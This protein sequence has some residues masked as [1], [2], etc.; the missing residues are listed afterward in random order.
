[1]A[2]RPKKPDRD[3]IVG[4]AKAGLSN[5]ACGPTAGIM[6]GDLKMVEK[7]YLLSSP[8]QSPEHFSIN[9]Q[10]QPVAVKDI[11]TRGLSSLGNFHSHPSAPP[12][13][14]QEDIRLAYDPRASYLILSLVE[15]MLILRTFEIVG[16][17]V[18]L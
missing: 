1:M 14:S 18:T 3:A 17:A 8:D 16:G 12:Q 13:P 15:E 9:P 7:M 5:E 4:H 6:Q 11:R 10:E 2:V